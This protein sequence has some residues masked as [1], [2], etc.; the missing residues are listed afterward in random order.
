MRAM[1]KQTMIHLAAAL[2]ALPML[3]QGADLQGVFEAAKQRSE[4]LGQAEA[5]LAKADAIKTEAVG[6]WLPQ[7]QLKLAE[8][9]A[10][11]GN[12]SLQSPGLKLYGRQNL[13]KG[14]DQ[15]AALRAG[16]AL[17]AQARALQAKAIQD[18]ASQVGAAYFNV[19]NV[20]ERIAIERAAQ[21]VADAAEKDLQQRVRL[22]RNRVAE[23]SSA[24][25]QAARVR[26][27]LAVL[28]GQ[29]SE[30]R[31]GLSSLSGLPAE[32]AL[33]LPSPVSGEAGADIDPAA[34]IPT[35]DAAQS[36]L[37]VAEAKRL[38]VKGGF[39]PTLYAEG[40]W[41]A[42]KQGGGS[43]PN[44]D[45]LLGVDLPIFQGGAQLARLKQ[46]DAD[47]RSAQLDLDLAKRESLREQLQARAALGLAEARVQASQQAL[48]AAEKSYADQQRDFRDSIVSSLDAIRAFDAVESARLEASNARWDAQRARLRLRL[49]FGALRP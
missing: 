11:Q 28:E 12:T 17:K 24:Q 42:V 21:D 39:L 33:E 9:F 13:L 26:A 38:S 29:L 2:L 23:L 47:L 3:A 18:L 14:L 15:P 8:G 20:E 5:A 48:A 27:S 1:K 6:N 44:W 37:T 45:A 16:D 43:S 40:N 10:D 30:A 36:A 4:R 34:G 35:V 31:L 46:A 22:G 41:Y 32:E 25:A 49:A 19:M 7:L